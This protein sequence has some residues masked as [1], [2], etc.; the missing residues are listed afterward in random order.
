MMAAPT[1]PEISEL[2]EQLKATW[3]AGD[4]G[5]VAEGLTQGAAAFFQRLP[6]EPG[7]RMLDVA[8]GTGQMAIPAA[9]AGARVTGIDIAE[10]WIAQARTQAAAEGLDARFDVGDAE[11]MPYQDAEFDL[12]ISM[13]GVMFAPRPE[14]AAAELL[15]VCRPGGRIVLGNWAPDGFVGEF[16]RTVGQYVPPPPM[17]SP[18]LWG[19]EA[20]VRERL[21]EGVSDLRMTPRTLRFDYPMSPAEVV[22]HYLAHFGPTKRACEALD[23]DGQAALRA[24][25]LKLWSDNHIPEDGAPRVDASILEVLAVRA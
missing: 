7:T 11:A 25:L 16:F 17:P 24:D 22:E 1:T 18:L 4:Y 15:R 13:I 10:N 8:C 12:V 6:V 9:R 23:A 20:T 5:Q 14:R 21:G 19:D 3:T 2:K